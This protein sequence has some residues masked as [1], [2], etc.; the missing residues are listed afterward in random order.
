VPAARVVE[1]ARRRGVLVGASGPSRVRV[2]LHLDVAP[3]RVGPAGRAL[4]E[5]LREALLEPRRAGSIEVT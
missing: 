2:V 5:A 3:S 1:A 4:A